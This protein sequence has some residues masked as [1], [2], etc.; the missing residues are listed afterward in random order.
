MV[1][2]LKILESLKPA[3]NLQTEGLMKMLTSEIL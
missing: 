3:Q 2:V 1:R